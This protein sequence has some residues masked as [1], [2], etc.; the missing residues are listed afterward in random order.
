MEIVEGTVAP[1]QFLSTLLGEFG[2]SFQKVFDLSRKAEP[3][4]PVTSIRSGKPFA[5]VS[6]DTCFHPDYFVYQP[7]IYRYLKFN[8]NN[9]EIE[10]VY[11][12]IDT[13]RRHV[14]GIVQG[15]LWLTMENQN[16]SPAIIDRME[17]ALAWSV[18]FYHI[19][20]GDEFKL[21]FDEYYIDGELAGVGKLYGAYYQ[22]TS[23]DYYSIHFTSDEYDGYYDEQGRPMKKAFLKSPVKYGRISSRYNLRRFHPVL[24]RTKAPPGYGITQ[25]P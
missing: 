12:P 8:L 3:I 20:N 22:T 10:E 6:T 19:Q 7:S 1:N 4:F 2:V 13:I 25:L 9:L 21:V 11:K 15:S 5:I 23:Q 14:G 24:K 18:D 16:I 17:D